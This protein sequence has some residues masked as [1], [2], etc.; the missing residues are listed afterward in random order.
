MDAAVVIS[1]LEDTEKNA[2]MSPQTANMRAAS[3]AADYAATFDVHDNSR[4]L[5]S[6]PKGR[7]GFPDRCAWEWTSCQ[8]P[9]CQTNT[10]VQRRCSS[11]APSGSFPLEVER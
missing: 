2:T 10:R 7:S 8:R 5:L 9:S 3:G 1:P 11:N 4:R 6:S